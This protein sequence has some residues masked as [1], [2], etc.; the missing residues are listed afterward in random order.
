MSTNYIF[1]NGGAR[2]SE[3][4][5]RERRQLRAYVQRAD[6]AKKHS[7]TH[8]PSGQETPGAAKA[9]MTLK[10]RFNET[11]H[12]RGSKP[13]TVKY[14]GG[15]SAAA[16]ADEDDT[17]RDEFI[18]DQRVE[19]LQLSSTVIVPWQPPLDSS[20]V[21]PFNWLPFQLGSDDAALLH[22]FQNYERWP[23]CPINGCNEWSLF[24][25]SDELVFRVTM[26]SW[27]THIRTRQPKESF[28]SSKALQRSLHDKAKAISI[29]NK[30][31]SDP[32]AACSDELLA[33][34]A[35]LT[36][37]EVSS[38]S[39]EEATA[40][41]NG[42]HALVERRGGLHTLNNARQQLVQRLAAWNDLLY[43]E[44]YGRSITFPPL[45]LWD[46]AWRSLPLPQYATPPL[47][48]SLEYLLTAGTIGAEM[49]KILHGVRLLSELEAERAHSSLSD[50]MAMY[51]NDSFHS[52]EY[53]L[54]RLVEKT[55]N[56]SADRLNKL[57]RVIALTTLVYVHHFLRGSPLTYRA[58]GVLLPN[59][60]QELTE[61]EGIW[62]LLEYAPRLH[63]WLLAVSAVTSSNWGDL[64]RSCLGWLSRL[65][66]LR[67]LDWE[68]FSNELRLFLW[69]GADDEVR[70]HR[71]WSE[72]DVFRTEN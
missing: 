70:Y 47:T 58:F 28:Q 65:C 30:R 23:W 12:A 53:Q 24:T 48:S 51:R 6:R 57:I 60:V 52:L 18:R 71:L 72:L 66:Q 1:I 2:L 55:S 63:L 37:I 7:P 13:A 3:M 62:E 15:R 33:A 19:T 29:I 21:D 59:L 27:N 43:G 68:A 45:E 38:G 67:G 10:F 46:R 56:Q 20:G 34:V 42:L 35:A 50:Q 39:Q 36:N 4:P 64:H 8:Q 49:T 32:I 5:L 17:N 44:L 16:S 22:Q 9:G 26:Y 54:R 40:H 11:V 61:P 31:L 69:C 14:S 25:L 41:I